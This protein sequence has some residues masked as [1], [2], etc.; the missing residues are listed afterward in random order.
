M[1]RKTSRGRTR[2]SSSTPSKVSSQLSAQPTPHFSSA[3]TL[4]T[5]FTLALVLVVSFSH[6][7]WAAVPATAPATSTAEPASQQAGTHVTYKFTNPRVPG[8]DY[9]DT[10]PEEVMRLLPTDDAAYAA[11]DKISPKALVPA[12][13][14]TTDAS[15]HYVRVTNT[16]AKGKVHN[17]VWTFKGWDR[18]SATAD[19]S[20]DVTFT[21]SWQYGEEEWGGHLLKV[22]DGKI[23]EG[24][25]DGTVPFAFVDSRYYDGTSDANPFNLGFKMGGG[26]PT[27]PTATGIT[28]TSSIAATTISMTRQAPTAA[29]TP[30]S[31]RTARW[32]RR[33]PRATR[34]TTWVPLRRARS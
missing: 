11:G 9:A 21:G 25:P 31:T 19:G 24:T 27:G 7:A 13:Q 8:I 22:E 12:G 5:M 33:N 6:T 18:S 28:P 34:S 14:T 16:D 20:T 2:V 1:E 29:T 3:L 10:L 17:G 30:P 4:A 23:V 15:V 32:A 26:N